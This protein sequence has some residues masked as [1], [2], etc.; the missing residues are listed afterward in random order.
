MTDLLR[1]FDERQR[2]RL[3]RSL[4]KLD[5]D[6]LFKSEWE[7]VKRHIKAA[8]GDAA[9]AMCRPHVTG[10]STPERRALIEMEILTGEVPLHRFEAGVIRK[11]EAPTLPSLDSLRKELLALMQEWQP[12]VKKFMS[13][14]DCLSKGRRSTGTGKPQY[15]P[16]VS[17]LDDLARVSSLVIDL[18]EE[19]YTSL[20]DAIAARLRFQLDTY[21]DGYLKSPYTNLADYHRKARVPQAVIFALSTFI[22]YRTGKVKD[23]LNVADEIHRVATENAKSVQSTYVVKM[24][25]KLTSVVARKGNLESA[26]KIRLDVDGCTFTGEL[27]FGF[28]DGSAFSIRQSVVFGHSYLGN[29]FVRYP[30]TFHDVVFMDGQKK[31]MVSEEQMNEIFCPAS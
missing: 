25:A 5:Q 28:K 24:K 19:L 30:S 12:T 9:K 20:V 7:E 1:H 21:L 14:K 17:S 3:A 13:W 23:G 11:L 15:V 8:I 10:P 16:P 22:D 2:V 26:E 29:L 6:R 4:Q 18:T 27:R 31:R